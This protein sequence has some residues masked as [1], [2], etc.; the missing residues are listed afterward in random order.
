[1]L[2]VFKDSVQFSRSV[3][4]N[5]LQPHGL[6]HTR[7]PCPSPTSEA[8]SNSCSSS[9][10][11]HPTI[12]TFVV[13]FSSCLQSLPASGSFTMNQPFASG[14]QSIG[15]SASASVFL[16]NI[17]DWFPLLINCLSKWLY[18]FAFPPAVN[19]F[20]ASK[21]LPTFGKLLC[22]KRKKKEPRYR[23]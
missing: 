6:Q 5:S 23:T 16:M 2:L 12:S 14:D 20:C 15:V 1:M 17:Q 21:F 9:Q 13:P 11:C 10:W 3:V 18:H 7:L 19:M 4:S 22:I 8:C